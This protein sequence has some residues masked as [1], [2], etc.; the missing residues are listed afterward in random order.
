MKYVKKEYTASSKKL[1]LQTNIYSKEEDELSFLLGECEFY[2][3][4]FLMEVGRAFFSKSFSL[5]AQTGVW[6]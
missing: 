4:Y 5:T 6:P 1:Y 3:N 2:S